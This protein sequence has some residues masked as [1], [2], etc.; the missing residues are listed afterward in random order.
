MI[1]LSPE[2]GIFFY[3]PWAFLGL[4]GLLQGRG[5]RERLRNDPLPALVLSY[6]LLYS[7]Q[8]A[9]TA[10]W[11]YG[12]RYLIPVIPFLAL[13]LGRF[14][15]NS[16]VKRAMAAFSILPGILMALLG[17]FGEM[18]LPVHPVSNPLPLPQVSFSLRMLLDGHHSSWVLGAFFAALL[19]AC[20]IVLWIVLVRRTGIR[21]SSFAW[22]PFWLAL[23]IPSSMEDWGGKPDYYRGLM[24]EHRM[25][26]ELAAG[27]YEAALQDE[28]AP[29]AVVERY[30]YA[31][32]RAESQ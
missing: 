18:H 20:A 14:A 32:A 15:S 24:A 29:P 10:G 7:A 9:V 30:E 2:R 21:I 19:A 11:A 31:R 8:N 27:Y 23:A 3:M 17:V 12:Q 13:G 1:L 16:P 4:W 6:I 26:W 28:T 5:F 25:E 22:L